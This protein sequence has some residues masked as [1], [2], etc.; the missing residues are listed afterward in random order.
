MALK[1]KLFDLFSPLILFPYLV[2]TFF[3]LGY[4]VYQKYQVRIQIRNVPPFTIFDLDLDKVKKNLKIQSMVY[5]FI[6]VLIFVEL[7]TSFFWGIGEIIDSDSKISPIYTVNKSINVKNGTKFI[8]KLEI[9]RIVFLIHCLPAILIVNLIFSILS[10]FQ[11]VLRRAFINLPYKIWV[12]RYT[13]YILVRLV[14]MSAMSCLCYETFQILPIIYALFGLFDICVYISSSRAFYVLLKGRRDEALYHSSQSDYLEKKRVTNNFF[15]GQILTYIYIFLG[16]IFYL[17][18]LLLTVISILRN[19]DFFQHISLGLLPKFYFSCKSICD[20]F[21]YIGFVLVMASTIL[22]GFCV[23]L[24]YFIICV[25]IL[26]KLFI[27][28]RKFNHVN[29][30]ITR[31]LMEDYRSALE[32]GRFHERPPFIQAFRSRLLY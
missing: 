11:I 31:P 8:Q 12:K 13:V 25:N 1:F 26:F 9:N 32:E 10:L 16:F 23:I 5:N 17:S 28:R 14:A 18:L 2:L 29:D 22:L 7:I 27:R 24:T 4:F 21:K 15:Y 20:Q 30:W 19:P 6:L 3:V